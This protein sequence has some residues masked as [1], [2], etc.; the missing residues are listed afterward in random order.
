MGLR[1]FIEY[2]RSVKVAESKK[3]IEPKKCYLFHSKTHEDYTY[4]GKCQLGDIL[5]KDYKNFMVIENMGVNYEY[6]HRHE[7]IK[8]MCCVK[9]RYSISTEFIGADIL[10]IEGMTSSYFMKNKEEFKKFKININDK[11]YDVNEAV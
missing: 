4:W 8:T 9:A 6:G 3:D 10:R 5:T 11:I 1:K 7:G 2:F